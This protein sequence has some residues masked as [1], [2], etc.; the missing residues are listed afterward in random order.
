MLFR[1]TEQSAGIGQVND[2][3]T[4]MD[5]VTQQNAA[6]VE[7]SAAAAA[8]LREQAE[9]LAQTVAVFRLSS[10]AGAT[11]AP[12]ATTPSPALKRPAPAPSAPSAASTAPKRT[13]TPVA[14][15]AGKSDSWEEF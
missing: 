15:T 3:I 14:A 4:Q 12:R 8:S 1:S 2:A 13:A 9:K 10:Y 5:Q 7:E 11:S 6:L